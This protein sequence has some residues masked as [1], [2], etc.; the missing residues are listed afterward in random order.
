RRK[1]MTI[2]PDRI[3]KGEV[4]AIAKVA[5][6]TSRFTTSS[7][8]R[9]TVSRATENTTAYPAEPNFSDHSTETDCQ[10]TSAASRMPH[11]S[12]ALARPRARRAAT[13][14]RVQ[15]ASRA[16]EVNPNG[17]KICTTPSTRLAA[18]SHREE[19][20]KASAATTSAPTATAAR[21]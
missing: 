1:R 2:S 3:T 4:T 18:S 13:G 6:S 19:T 9:K 15:V 8:I 16:T 20:L 10:T 7:A 11:T 5:P 21:I 12:G 14:K 17:P